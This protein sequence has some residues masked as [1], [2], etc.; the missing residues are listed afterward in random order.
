MAGPRAPAGAGPAVRRRAEP[1]A[2]RC[3]VGSRAVLWR[4]ASA[5]A[6]GD[7]RGARHARRGALTRISAVARASQGAGRH[8]RDQQAYMPRGGGGSRGGGGAD[9]TVAFQV[10][11]SPGFKE[12]NLNGGRHGGAE[13]AASRRRLGTS[14]KCSRAA[15]RAYRRRS[16]GGQPTPRPART[17][18]PPPR[19][20]L[21]HCRGHFP[22]TKATGVPACNHVAV[23]ARACAPTHPLPGTEPC[24]GP[25]RNADLFLAPPHRY[26]SLLLTEHR[27][28]WPA[29]SGNVRSSLW[30]APCA[31]AF[32]CYFLH[33]S[34]VITHPKAPL[35]DM[36]VKIYISIHIFAAC[37][38]FTFVS[39]T[40]IQ[41]TRA[42][43][44]GSAA[45]YQAD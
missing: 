5:G 3:R 31:P 20:R 19:A 38:I 4:D 9:A 37:L 32:E 23:G 6:R 28:T 45:F 27:F 11:P 2:S 12:T 1:E 26:F 21:G 44:G 24:R 36:Q 14:G 17:V 13:C 42:S 16:P 41:Q 35:K 40:K 7:G 8:L 18:L 30:V 39:R 15:R 25:V 43:K 34:L 22:P 29:R 10:L 33:P